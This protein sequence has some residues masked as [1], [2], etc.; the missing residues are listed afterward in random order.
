MPVNAERQFQGARLRLARTFQGFTLEDLGN[1]VSVTR[2]YVQR[3]EI[4]PA[5]IPSDDLLAALA[6]ALH[7]EVGFLFE[8]MTREVQEEVCHFRRRKTTPMHIRRRALSYGTIFN[9][10][11]HYLDHKFEFP[12]IDAQLLPAAQT[13][14][15]IER[16]AENCR[17][18]W[19]LHL[20]API[21][22]M[23]RTIEC[24]GGVVTTFKGVSNHVD[25]FSYV[26]SRPVVV[27]NTAKPS[28]SRARF[29]IA[30][31]LGHLVLHQGLETDEPRFEDEANRFAS[32][33]LLPR[34]AFI[35]EFPK[36]QRID[37]AELLKMKG[38]WGASLQAIIRRSYDLGLIGAVQYRN[39]HVYISRNGWKTSEPGEELI[40]VENPEIV[41][42]GFQLLAESGI[43]PEDVA[44]ELHITVS[45]MEKFEIPLPQR[46]SPAE[47]PNLISLA[48]ERDQRRKT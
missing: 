46:P 36:R 39:A 28:T 44:S 45:I 24:A 17:I 27:R 38:R 18:R 41:A 23:I 6:E 14:E 35:K 42:S 40:P 4:D 20:D 47:S 37:W 7:V 15:D 29:D 48:R 1:Q 32:A 33:F 10:I 9:A 5:T 25:A 12:E 22:N 34:V 43:Y 3:L 8:P 11:L 30:H 31:E 26:H 13:F 21:Q 16:A 19:G 2:Q